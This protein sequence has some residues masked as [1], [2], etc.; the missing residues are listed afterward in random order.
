MRILYVEKGNEK[1]SLFFVSLIQNVYW[2]CVEVNIIPV[3]NFK[4]QGGHQTQMLKLNAHRF[5]EQVFKG[6]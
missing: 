1:T 4:I 3:I 5:F 6:S 2:I